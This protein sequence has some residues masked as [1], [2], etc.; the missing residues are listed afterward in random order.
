[1]PVTYPAIPV[2]GILISA[3]DAPTFND[4]AIYPL[5]AKEDLINAVPDFDITFDNDTKF[6][7]NHHADPVGEWIRQVKQYMD[8]EIRTIN[9]LMELEDWDLFV[10]V[11]RSTDIFQHTLWA[12][13]E[14]VMNGEEVTEDESMRAEAVFAC[15]EEIDREFGDR[16]STKGTDRNMVVM[17]DHGFGMLHG[18]VCL[19]RVLADAGLLRFKQGRNRR[20]LR[21]Y[22]G[23][24]LRTHLSQKTRQKIKG[25]L[26]K[27]KSE[28]RWRTYVD[29]LVADIDWSRTKVFSVG[30]FGSLFVNL[31]G[32]DPM[33]T[34]E[35]EEER[36][37]VLAENEAALSRITDPRDGRQMVSSFYRKEELCHGPY[38]S[39]IPDLVVDL[40]DW[41]YSPVIGTA[42]ELSEDE[43]IREPIKEWK[44]LAHSGTHRR[45]GMLIVHGPDVVSAELGTAR[46]VD[47]APTIMNMMGLPVPSDFD[48]RLLTEALPGGKAMPVVGEEAMS[49][50][51]EAT[52][53]KDG[54][55]YTGT[56][57][58]EI[59][60]R[61]SD[62][63]YL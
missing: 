48:G 39:E 7:V 52:G 43:I 23:K 56:D 20:S 29:V 16:W 26:G 9:Y 50:T 57:E 3:V 25:L 1:M 14:K 32:H 34:V 11:I 24:K 36:Q 27:G 5:Q 46:L 37:A 55:A 35:S 8:M 49:E 58:E 30:G 6:L 40:R 4:R 42:N 31:K 10:A 38:M 13:A 12:G 19:N 41:S 45:E 54:S 33:G 47:V 51:G 15:Y 17:S 60:K 63:G 21:G 28:E 18:H 22:I 62:L 61:L 59:R 2:N 44:Q 53:R